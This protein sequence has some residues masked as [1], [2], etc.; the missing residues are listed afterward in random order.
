[1]KSWYPPHNNYILRKDQILECNSQDELDKIL[2]QCVQDWRDD[3]V[4][5]GELTWLEHF[6][7]NRKLEL[8]DSESVA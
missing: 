3:K 7:K 5:Y 2:N 4:Y 8:N 1:M 6:Y